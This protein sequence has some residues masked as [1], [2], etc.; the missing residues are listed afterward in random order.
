MARDALTKRTRNRLPRQLKVVENVPRSVNLTYQ[1]YLCFHVFI[2]ELKPR[3]LCMTLPQ[4]YSICGLE[5]SW[6]AFN[7]SA[8]ST[9]RLTDSLRGLRFHSS[10]FS[11]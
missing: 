3:L 11:R 4:T 10:D 2:P 9:S 1:Q 6:L 8:S 5:N 7:A